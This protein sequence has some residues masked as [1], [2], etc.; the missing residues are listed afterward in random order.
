[1]PRAVE[2][3]LRVFASPDK[4][5]V[6]TAE[7]IAAGLEEAVAKRGLARIAISGGATPKAVFELLADPAHPYL[8]RIPWAKTQF[9]WVDE[10]CVPPDDKE[11]N[12]GMTKTAMLDKVPLPAANVHRMG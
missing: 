5:N 4:V 1:M 7:Y 10:R 3:D 8:E 2:L 12:Y 9:F 11:S 6:A